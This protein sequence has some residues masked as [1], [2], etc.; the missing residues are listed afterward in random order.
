[1]GQ[2]LPLMQI[3]SKMLPSEALQPKGLT[4]TMPPPQNPRLY[5]AGP[6]GK[7]IAQAPNWLARGGTGKAAAVLGGY[8]GFYEGI[9][10]I[11]SQEM[12]NSACFPLLPTKGGQPVGRKP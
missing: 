12:F 5:P 8:L 2:I 7:G 9:P 10:H 1:M 11:L 6:K 3:Q 4:I